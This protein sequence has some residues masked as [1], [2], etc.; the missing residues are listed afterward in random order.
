MEKQAWHGAFM[1]MLVCLHSTL[2]NTAQ[3]WSLKKTADRGKIQYGGGLGG[4]LCCKQR[5]GPQCDFVFY[6][7]T[8]LLNQRT[9]GH[10]QPPPP[11]HTHT[12]THIYVSALWP[13]I[14]CHLLQMCVTNTFDIVWHF[15]AVLTWVYSENT[16][17]T[18]MSVWQIR[19]HH[20]IMEPTT[21]V[22]RPA[23][24]CPWLVGFVAFSSINSHS[25]SVFLWFCN[26][27]IYEL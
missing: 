1:G 21:V 11:T 4:L 6:V 24:I 14:S 27:A 3:S 22:T 25:S 5:S 17:T 7:N 12:H 2:N 16:D 18:L 23:K 20:F 9:K 8:E 10:T 15:V 26:S 19:R 13:A